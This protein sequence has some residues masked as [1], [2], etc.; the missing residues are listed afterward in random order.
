VNTALTRRETRRLKSPTVHQ[1]K[2]V[3]G[4]DIGEEV[5]GTC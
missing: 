3:A 4:G 1:N 2:V 5:D